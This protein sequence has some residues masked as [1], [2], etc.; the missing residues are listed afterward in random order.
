MDRVKQAI[1]VLRKVTHLRNAGQ[2]AA[3]ADK[4]ARMIDHGAAT[5]ADPSP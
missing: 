5:R 1:A 3:V 2:H 4:A